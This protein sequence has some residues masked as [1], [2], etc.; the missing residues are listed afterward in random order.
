M[1]FFVGVLA[2]AGKHANR[3]D[4]CS[5][6]EMTKSTDCAKITAILR[7]ISIK[8]IE[9]YQDSPRVLVLYE[10]KKNRR[11]QECYISLPSALIVTSFYRPA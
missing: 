2:S 5:V 6:V 4:D 3:Y 10:M 8:V 9:C 11:S 7:K 1:T